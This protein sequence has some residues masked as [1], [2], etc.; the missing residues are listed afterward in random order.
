MPKI[1]LTYFNAPG[2][3]EP[4][5]IALRIAQVPF[6]DNRIDYHQFGALKADGSLPIGSV[7]ILAVDDLVLPQTAA[8]LR[9]AARLG[10]GSLYPTDAF[11]AFLVDSVVDSFNDTLSGALSPSYREQD[12]EKRLAM[13]RAFVEGTM[14]RV[15]THL[16]GLLARSGGPFLLGARMTIADLL[17]GN[18]VVQLQ[19]GRLDG[20][21]AADLAPWPRVVALAAAYEAEPRVVASRAG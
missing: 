8:M 17:V 20:I 14:T 2:R 18:Q 21:T 10:D 19:S 5:R 6:T 4:V 15:L 12:P 7:P 11:E 16:E 9:Y 1:A 3:A 13:R